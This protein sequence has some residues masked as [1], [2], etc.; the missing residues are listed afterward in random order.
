MKITRLSSI[1]IPLLVFDVGKS[2]I[3][4]DMLDF[5]VS[6]QTKM[7]LPSLLLLDES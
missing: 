1:L 2:H 7:S 6:A 3:S 4:A 5:S